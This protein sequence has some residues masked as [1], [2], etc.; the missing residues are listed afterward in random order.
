MT[1]KYFPW[2]RIQ[3]NETL[4]KAAAFLQHPQRILCVAVPCLAM[5]AAYG[6][7]RLNVRTQSMVLILLI[8]SVLPGMLF[9]QE[10]SSQDICCY[11]GEIMSTNAE[12]KEYLYPDTDVTGVVSDQY[13]VS[14]ESI[15]IE[16]FQKDGTNLSFR[17]SAGQDGTLTL[18]LFYYEGY[19]V[20]CEGDQVTLFRGDNNRI[21]ITVYQGNEGN[22]RVFYKEPALWRVA[23]VI[24]VLTV[25]GSI[26]F[27]S[28]SKLLSKKKR[29]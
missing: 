14:D 16:E 27:C 15:V 11:Q 1:T 6:Y 18:P 4:A 13:L 20:E 25:N 28:K 7:E 19:R 26:L 23:D 10:Y 17:Y 22:V 2:S 24:S 8:L 3:E 9:L 29:V 21:G 5:A 12:T